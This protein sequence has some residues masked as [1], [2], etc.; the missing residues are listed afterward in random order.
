MNLRSIAFTL[1]A[2]APSLVLAAFGAIFLVWFAVTRPKLLRHLRA[3]SVPASLLAGLCGMVLLQL[4]A[5]ALLFIT[6]TGL[7]QL[8]GAP[9]ALPL[10]V[11][12]LVALAALPLG[13][14]IR[15]PDEDLDEANT[16]L[17]ELEERYVRG[18]SDG[19]PK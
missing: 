9:L 2:G 10:W 19:R 13:R 1:T 11:A 18:R 14:W 16:V 7:A 15:S 12:P 5:I 3:T 4:L 8:L 6:G 17:D